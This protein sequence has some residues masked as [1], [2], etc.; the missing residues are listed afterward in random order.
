MVDKINSQANIQA[1]LSRLRAYEAQASGELPSVDKV[2]PTETSKADF[3]ALVREAVGS[4]NDLQGRAQSLQAAYESG[5]P[6]AM[7]DVVLGMQKASLAFEATL[8][9]RNKVL[10]A[11]EEIIN[12]PV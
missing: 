7:T 8:Q 2:A 12:M 1:M 5:Q 3:G 11:Y 9:V 10:K 6:V 4:V